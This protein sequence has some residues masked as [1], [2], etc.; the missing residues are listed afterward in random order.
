MRFALVI[1]KTEPN[2]SADIPG[3][4]AIGPTIEEPGQRIREAVQFHLDE[5]RE[6]GLPMPQPESQFEYVEIAP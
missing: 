3:C 4:V 2:Y 1:E 6:D 5:L